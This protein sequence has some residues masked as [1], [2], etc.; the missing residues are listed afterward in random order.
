MEAVHMNSDSLRHSTLIIGATSSL[1]EA[2]AATL[3]QKN[4]RLILAGRDESELELVAADLQTRYLTECKLL[5]GDFLEPGFSPELFIDRAGDFDDA[6]IMTGD[7]G[8]GD[9]TDL[10]NLAYTAHINYILPAQLATAIAQRFADKKRGTLALISS[11]AGDRG[12]QS[13]YAYGSAKAALSTF[14]SGLRNRFWRYGV[15]V[16]T[17]KPGFIDTPMTWGMQSRLIATREHVARDIVRAIQKK[18]N[19]VY[20]PHRWACIMLIITHI[21]EWMFKRLK[22]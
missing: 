4:Q 14:A 19:T 1:A 21:P 10:I 7:M 15:H 22:L 6:I 13:N 2:I 3:A 9:S 18:K 8:N 11:V 5:T 16:I 17:V 12:R 20:V